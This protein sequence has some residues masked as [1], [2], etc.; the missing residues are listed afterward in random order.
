MVNGP[1]SILRSKRLLYIQNNLKTRR[2]FF[3]TQSLVRLV[4]YLLLYLSTGLAFSA[5][6]ELSRVRA[7]TEYI[8][9]VDLYTQ[10]VADLEGRFGPYDRS[11]LEPLDALISLRSRAGDFEEINA[12]LARQL[13]LVH[14]TEG[15][16]TFSQL[17][18]LEALITN[19]LKIF[20][21]GVITNN[22]ESIQYVFSQNS[23]ST[24][25]QKL[26]SMRNLRSWYLTAF[27]LD[28]KQSRLSYFMKSRD[29]LQQMLKMVSDA[30]VASDDQIVS[31][32]YM[33]AL[34]KYYLMTLL[35][36]LDELGADANDY[37]F[38]PERTQPITYLRQGY[39]IV[40]D[41][42]DIVRSNGDKEAEGMAVVYEADW[43]MLLGLGIARRTYREAMEIF[44][45]AGVEEQKIKDF[46]ARPVVLPVTEYYSSIDE[47][48]YAQEAEGYKFIRGVSDEDPQVYLGNYPAWNE[49][50]P[51]TPMPTLP[52]LLS[53]IE[54][55]LT[56]VEMRFRISSRGKTR[57]PDAESSDPDTVRAR[58]TAED[59]LKEMVFRPRFVGSRW[60][61]LE[62]LTMTYWYPTEK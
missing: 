40:K 53:D 11:L 20:D 42:S 8:R 21:L 9:Q 16:N 49:S 52:D 18:I 34:E 4:A 54:L 50:V 35:A 45:E 32:L 12:L 41:I 26:E 55:D 1:K 47:A 3:S 7:S 17:P 10:E 44:A 37:I 13:Q 61:P 31:F 28:N 15:P 57:G 59:A 27:N 46:F 29:L 5:E 25:G 43:Q 6:E 39:E 14:V 38:V 56:Q 24:V 19:N 51:Y 30:Y 22:F 36:S 60:R 23:E 48:N 62:N 2:D 33:E 58:R